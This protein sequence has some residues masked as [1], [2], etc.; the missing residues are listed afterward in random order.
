MCVVLPDLKVRR[1]KRASELWGSQ[2]VETSRGEPARRPRRTGG[3][4]GGKPGVCKA[5]SQE[6]IR[7]AGRGHLRRKWET[8]TEDR[9]M[10]SGFGSGGLRDELVG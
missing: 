6:Q 10:S 8:G 3:E 2:H 7:V 5:Q 1:S 9:D 4:V